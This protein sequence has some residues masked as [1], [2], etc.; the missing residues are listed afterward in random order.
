MPTTCIL[1]FRDLVTEE[2]GTISE[3]RRLATLKGSVWWGWWMRQYETSPQ[4][5]FQ[6][7]SERI[8]RGGPIHIYLLN[9]GEARIFRASL[10]RILAAP[11]NDKISTPDASRTPEYYQR[12]KYPAWFSLNSIDEVHWHDTVFYYESFPTRPERTD[13]V[14]LLEQKVKTIDQ[15]RSIDVTLWSVNDLSEEEA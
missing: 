1:R 12:G 14:Q 7:L 15:L 5:Y 13:W 6:T 10:G 4:A 9:A 3:H 2:G 8:V 11:F